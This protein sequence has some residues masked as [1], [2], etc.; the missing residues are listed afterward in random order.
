MYFIVHVPVSSG[1][2]DIKDIKDVDAAIVF[3][4]MH[5]LH[6]KLTII[7]RFSGHTL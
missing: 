1:F 6:A 2:D 4:P 3:S 7:I 5:L